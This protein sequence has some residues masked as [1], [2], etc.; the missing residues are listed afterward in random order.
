MVDHDGAIT[1]PRSSAPAKHVAAASGKVTCIINGAPEVIRATLLRPVT[2]SWYFPEPDDPAH[3]NIPRNSRSP[4]KPVRF[5]TF[6]PR[7]GL[8]L[9]P[10]PSQAK[11]TGQAF[12]RR[13]VRRG[14]ARF[15]V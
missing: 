15:A 2:L 1:A 8:T 11:R 13:C 14:V 9:A 4:G 3:S 12:N 6:A 5:V 7:S 10:P